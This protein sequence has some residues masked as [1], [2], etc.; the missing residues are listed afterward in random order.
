[1]K[2]SRRITNAEYR[3]LTGAIAKTASRDLEDLV[4][5]GVLEVSVKRGRGAAYNLVPKKDIIRKK[6]ESSDDKTDRFLIT[7][8]WAVPFIECDPEGSNIDISL[9]E[10]TSPIT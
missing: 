2:I 7:V 6:E 8:I 5:K 9:I 4:A 3:K 1:M 10:H